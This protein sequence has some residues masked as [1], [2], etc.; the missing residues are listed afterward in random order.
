MESWNLKSISQDCFPMV[1]LFGQKKGKLTVAQIQQT[2]QLDLK[3]NN[4]C[5]DVW[6]IESYKVT[7]TG[8]EQENIVIQ[9]AYGF[10]SDHLSQLLQKAKSGNN[11]RFENIFLINQN[12]DMAAGTDMVFKIK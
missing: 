4:N 2:L 5:K 12:G 10:C 3:N 1:S 11:L 9:N 8:S 7:M 6:E